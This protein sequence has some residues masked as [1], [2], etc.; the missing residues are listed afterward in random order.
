MTIQI[1]IVDGSS[2]RFIPVLGGHVAT[3]VVP[4]EVRV[5][6]L[7]S[8]IEDGDDDAPAG[9]AFRPRALHVHVETVAS[10][11]QSKTKNKVSRCEFETM[12][13]KSVDSGASLSVNKIWTENSNLGKK[14]KISE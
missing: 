13:I 14:K 12:E 11:L 4:D 7:E 8:V 10:V 6:F 5:V 2:S 1:E 9:D 3:H